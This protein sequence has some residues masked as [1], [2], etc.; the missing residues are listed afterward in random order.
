MYRKILF[1]LLVLSLVSLACSFNINLPTTVEPGPT[2]VDQI[3]IPL[4]S[5]AGTVDLT[6]SFGA[7]SLVLNPGSDVLVSGTATYNLDEFQPV[8]TQDGTRVS[9]EQG[10]WNLTGIPDMSELKNEWNLQLGSVPLN[11]SINAGAYSAEYE[12]GGLALEYLSVSDGAADVELSFSAPNPVE[13]SLLRY[14]TGASSVSLTGLANANFSSL[15]FDCGAGDYNLDFSGDLQRDGSVSIET[16]VSDMTLVITAGI[17]V[18][19]TVEGGLANVTYG[20]GWEK[21]GKVYTQEG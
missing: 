5:A 1:V 11:L 10:E 21:N 2:V 9:L 16:G 13:M 14:Q 19:I 15:E 8:I 12:F 17:P 18:Q 6:L 3:D 20:S 7:G 4:P